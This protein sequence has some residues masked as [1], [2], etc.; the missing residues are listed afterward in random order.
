MQQTPFH[1]Y[2]VARMPSG[3]MGSNALIPAFA[4]SNIEIYPYQIAAAQFALRSPY[5]HGVIL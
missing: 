5:L 4:S 2:Y 1:A 3:F